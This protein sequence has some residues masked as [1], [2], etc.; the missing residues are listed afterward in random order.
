MT[1]GAT[2]PKPTPQNNTIIGSS[3]ARMATIDAPGQ[4]D[5]QRVEL[6]FSSESPV[7]RWFGEEVLSHEKGAIEFDRLEKAAPLLMGHNWDDQIGVVESVRLDGDKKTRAVVRFSKSARGREIYQDVIDGI[8]ANVSV[9]YSIND[10]SIQERDGQPDLV[11]VTRWSPHEISLVSVPADINVGVGRS[12]EAQPQEPPKMAEAKAAKTEER[13]ASKVEFDLNAEMSKFREAEHKRVSEISKLAAKFGESDL[14]QRFIEENKTVADFQAIIL[15]KVSERSASPK[16]VAP[17]KTA[18]VGMNDREVKNYSF[19]RAINAL[20]NPQSRTAQE[21][22]S[23]EFECSEAA[24]QRYGKDAK[25]LIIPQDVLVRAITT[26]TT[27]TPA[28]ATG[29]YSVATDL[30]AE[31]FIDLLRN[32]TVLMGL[33]TSLTGLVGNIDI[34]KQT[35]GAAGVWIAT[36]GGNANEDN[37]EL[38]QV[39]LTPKTV[40][41]YTEV[42]RKLLKQSSLDVESMVRMDLASA[43][44]TAID[45]AGL[46]GTGATGQPTGAMVAAGINTVDFATAG[47]PTWAEVIDCETQIAADNAD[48]SSMAYLCD[49]TMRGWLK[50]NPKVATNDTFMWEPGDTLNGY[51]AI[52]TNQVTSND[53]L[54]AN[55][56]DLLMGMWGGLDLT[57]DPYSNS[58]SGTLRIVVH[59]DV[60]I[61]IRHAESFCLGRLI[62]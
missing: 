21:A 9:G 25:G 37:L 51:R 40:A 31:S 6:S 23:F 26:S 34:P 15:E 11:T 17:A 44:G 3:V 32:R 54:F 60:D 5:D 4:N 35:E 43:L 45:L 53:L 27:G 49:A 18:D 48:V 13:E 10:I 30:L 7:M 38:G 22:A 2:M 42:T 50:S 29:G 19:V 20:A 41:A 12:H 55:W 47:Q 1:T 52:V 24:A 59:Q 28:G 33:A 39:S 14:G 57:V 16:P 46:Y 62:P 36:E 8:R 56:A 58:L 61:A